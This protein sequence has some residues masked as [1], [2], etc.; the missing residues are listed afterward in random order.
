MFISPDQVADTLADILDQDLDEFRNSAAACSYKK[1]GCIWEE[2]CRRIMPSCSHRITLKQ[3][4]SK[5]YWTFR[6]HYNT[7]KNRYNAKRDEM[8]KNIA[9]DTRYSKIKNPDDVCLI[10]TG[11]LKLRCLDGTKFPF[12]RARDK[13][14]ANRRSVVERSQDVHENMDLNDT[15][16]N[17]SCSSDSNGNVNKHDCNILKDCTE[18]TCNSINGVTCGVSD[19]ILVPREFW[20]KYWTGLKHLKRGWTDDKF[21][22]YFEKR[23]VECVI[24]F[25]DHKFYN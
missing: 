6:R 12:S 22:K 1:D 17:S 11:E 8:Q 4:T 23:F 10:G 15:I 18:I 3:H 19:E 20:Q 14:N 7:I 16:D 2:V 25:K 13:Q 5:C 24:S 21:H 9:H